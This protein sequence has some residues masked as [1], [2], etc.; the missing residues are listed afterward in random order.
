VWIFAPET[1]RLALLRQVLH[2][3]T[4]IGMQRWNRAGPRAPGDPVKPS[5][6]RCQDPS[7]GLTKTLVARPAASW[8]G[9]LN[10]L[11]RILYICCIN[12]GAAS[13]S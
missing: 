9:H 7:A 2:A 10:S 4:S 5:P 12:I 3:K 11:P 13:I 8:S 1:G 6:T